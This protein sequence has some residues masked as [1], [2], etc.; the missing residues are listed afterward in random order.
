MSIAKE[1]DFLSITS[2]Q[3]SRIFQDINKTKQKLKTLHF[4]NN[5]LQYE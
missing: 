5:Y 4:S 3:T 2:V 1:L